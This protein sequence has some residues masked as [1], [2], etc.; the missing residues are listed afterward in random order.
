MTTH[1]H[2]DATVDTVCV[3]ER[4]IAFHDALAV[5]VGYCLGPE[6]MSWT[7][8]PVGVGEDLGARQRRAFA[9]QTYD[10]IAGSDAS[11][12]TPVDVLVADGLNAQMRS[13][14]IAG[15]LAVAGEV[16]TQLARI[17]EDTNFWSLSRDDVAKRPH[18]EASLAWPI[19]RAWTI[20][21]G[22]D[23]IDVARAHKIL[24]HKRPTVFPLIDNQTI[25][26]LNAEESAWGAIHDD[27]SSTSDGW[28]KLEEAVAEVLVPSGGPALAR[29]RLHDILLWTRVAR[30]WD[31]ALH[32][33]LTCLTD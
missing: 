1:Q 24:H 6:P 21:M 25:N 23:G 11:D 16:S 8:S 31:L 19:W 13:K 4:Q 28:S 33:G 12:L 3:A 9:Y 30:R 32:L 7:G 18:D 15:V 17:D 20:L 5:I 22:V 2:T 29:L 10:C 14:D 26:L 27:L